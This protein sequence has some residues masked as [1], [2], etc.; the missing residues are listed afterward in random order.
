MFKANTFDLRKIFPVLN[1]NP[2]EAVSAT[3]DKQIVRYPADPFRVSE[4]L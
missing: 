2:Y 1:I 3:G 4:F